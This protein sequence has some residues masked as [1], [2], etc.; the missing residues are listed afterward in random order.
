ME[1]KVYYRN[2]EGSNGNMG[3]IQGIGASESVTSPLE[4]RQV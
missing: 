1:Q 3:L 4:F 2:G